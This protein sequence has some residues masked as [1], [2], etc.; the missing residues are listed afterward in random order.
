[1]TGPKSAS[2][3]VL[4]NIMFVI[5]HIQ[6]Y[7]LGHFPFFSLHYFRQCHRLPILS[8]DTIQIYPMCETRVPSASEWVSSHDIV[9]Q[10][11]EV[12]VREGAHHLRLEAVHKVILGFRWIYK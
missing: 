5:S 4:T 9:P 11:G 12:N 8:V 1:M 10:E 3:N 6:R 2:V 7:T